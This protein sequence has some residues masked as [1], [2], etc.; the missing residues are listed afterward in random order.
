MIYLL[1]F[2]PPFVG[3]DGRIVKHYIGRT[4]LDLDERFAVH[5]AGHGAALIRALIAQGGDFVLAR[6]WDDEYAK[7][8][9]DTERALKTRY[10]SGYKRACPVCILKKELK[11][12][13]V[14]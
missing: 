11:A 7:S 8:N 5:R 13:I 9:Y 10:K 14:A 3:S 1:H 6:T 2:D 12:V 4:R